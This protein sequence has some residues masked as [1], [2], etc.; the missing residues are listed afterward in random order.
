MRKLLLAS[1]AVFGG[2]VG[3]QAMAQ[4]PAPVAAPLPPTW[5]EGG[6]LTAPSGVAGAND[7]VNSQG[8]YTKGPVPE[9]T[10]G[11]ITVRWQGRVIAYGYLQSSSAERY[12]TPATT[13]RSVGI[14]NGVPGIV[15]TTNPAVNHETAPYGI[16]GYAR[17]YTGMDGMTT[18]GLRYG[19]AVEIRVNTGLNTGASTES[20]GS[21]GATA[22]QTLYIRR[23]F[24]YIGGNWG[25]VHLGQDD[26]PVSLL[27]AGVTTFQTFNDGGL[28]DDLNASAGAIYIWPFLS[29]IG[30]EYTTSKIVYLSP[31]VYG[32]DFMASF[33]PNP[34]PLNDVTSYLSTN[35][36]AI[37]TGLASS[38]VNRRRNTYEVGLRYQQAVGPASVYAFGSFTGSGRTSPGYAGAPAY[39]NLNIWFGGA[40]INFAGL[41]VGGA[42]QSGAVNNQMGLKLDG[43][44]NETAYTLGTQYT[45]GPMT[46]GAAY[47][48]DFTGGSSAAYSLTRSTRHQW[49]IEVGG[50]YVIAPGL[51]GFLSASYVHRYQGGYNFITGGTGSAGNNYDS[52]Q[53]ALGALVRW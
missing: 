49:A 21:S 20:G 4:V 31:L 15:T 17:F 39:D 29:G 45:V 44:P 2:F 1:A 46:V 6:K 52:K 36:P 12:V 50:T 14:V 25:A 26:G 5:T 48:Q 23:A 7:N 11:S 51:L 35:A 9:P 37:S 18:G 53:V 42:I 22:S 40:A 27:D 38:E 47:L 30:N 24:V 8:Y 13:S 19:G 16:I 33:E 10:P 43:M 34:N 41:R 28:N 3:G 32:F